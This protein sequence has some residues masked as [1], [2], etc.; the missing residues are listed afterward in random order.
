MTK[1][2]TKTKDATR[3]PVVVILGH[4]DHGKTT[5]LDYIRKARVAAKEAGG[6]TQHI[7]AYQAEAN[8]KLITFL[9]TPG[10]EAFSAI[11][12]RGAQVADI[13]V[14]VIAAEEGL[15]P[16]TKEAIKIIK[17][18]KTPFVVAINKVDKE[19]ANPQRVRQ[20]LAENEV[21]VEDYGGDVPVAEI[22]GLT[23]KG[24][25][26][27]LELILLLAEVE[28]LKGE[29]DGA[30]SG[31]VIESHLDSRRGIVA[32][33][34]V[35]SGT[36]AIGDVISAGTAVAK[37]KM[38]ENFLGKGV[39]AA[40]PSE[41][42][43][44]LGWEAVPALGSAFNVVATHAEAE[45]IAKETQ[46]TIKLFAHET[47]ANKKTANLII[48]ADVQSSLEAIDQVLRTIKSDE[49]DY[50]V[51]GHGV[52]KIGDADIK[53]AKSTQAA[54]I[55]FHVEMDSSVKHL[56]EREQIRV[57]TFDI[58]YN[59]VEVVRDIMSDLL[60]PEIKRTALGKL[61]I[62]ALFGTQG[63]TQIV[64]GK[65]TN[66]KALRGG[67]LEIVRGGKIIATGKIVQLQQKKADVAEVAEGLE[68]GLR[69]DVNPTDLGITIPI[70]ENDLLDMYQEEKIKRSI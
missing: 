53:Q 5:I 17:E 33:L 27:L 8:G 40:L 23:G 19:A 52:G 22:S 39:K 46:S 57:E 62:L 66:G 56:A 15:K 24:I 7:G 34:L 21:M 49:V 11:R 42:C 26:H 36:L 50:K 9:D 51:V 32:T 48:K 63:K 55:A 10:H 31:V 67:L 1:T 69:V 61:K 44:V 54:I 59:L 65:V 58:I 16:Q 30:A 3:P 41:P 13:A 64:G 2:Q 37:V 38:L 6:I 18:S 47:D 4:V 45:K 14:L 20:E 43:V 12:S 29:A 35:K 60:P 28:E 68:C 70:K 25:D